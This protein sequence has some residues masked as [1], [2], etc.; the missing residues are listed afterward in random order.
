M[1][2]T[3][4][5]GIVL[6]GF[7]GYLILSKGINLISSCVKNICVANEWKN[8]YKYGKE[9]NMVPPGY[10]RQTNVAPDGS[11]EV[12]FNKGG[13]EKDKEGAQKD[14]GSVLGD[15]LGK[16]IVDVFGSP[17]ASE[18]ASESD[19]EGVSKDISDAD[20]DETQVTDDEQYGI[21]YSEDPDGKI[22]KIKPDSNWIKI[23]KDDVRHDVRPMT[24]DTDGDKIVIP[25]GGPDPKLVEMM[26]NL[27]EE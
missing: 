11:G 9:G 10:S 26:K 25:E 3:K 15:A 1:V 21:D 16:A 17:E 22:V 20:A 7:A 12:T 8:Y 13:I 2:K 27:N 6:G 18:E 19:S 14:V 23:D 24:G 4:I 5:G